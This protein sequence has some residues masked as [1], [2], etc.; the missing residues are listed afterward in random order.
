MSDD[1]E[2]GV[3][4]MYRLQT[5][6][7]AQMEELNLTMS[8]AMPSSGM[9]DAAAANTTVATLKKDFAGGI[10]QNMKNM[11]AVSLLPGVCVNKVDL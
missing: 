10:V 9:I 8:L 6:A 11:A 1:G 3:L 2:G 4:M 5:V 7:M